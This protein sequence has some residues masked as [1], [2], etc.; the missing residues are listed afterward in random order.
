[1]TSWFDPTVIVAALGVV[2][3]ASIAWSVALLRRWKI[4]QA[5]AENDEARHEIFLHRQRFFEMYAKVSGGQTE[6]D[7]YCKW[8]RG[9]DNTGAGIP[10][11]HSGDKD[12][13]YKSYIDYL[14]AIYDSNAYIAKQAHY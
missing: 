3:T 11:L 4:R 2:A 7:K 6:L 12:E 10:G 5:N 13:A 1:M 9:L 8:I 14:E